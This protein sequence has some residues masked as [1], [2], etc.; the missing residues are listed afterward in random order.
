MKRNFFFVLIAALLLAPWPVVYAYDGVNAD[1]MT[2]AI[3]PAPQEYGPQLQA[4][5]GAVGHVTPGDLFIIDITGYDAD[6]NYELIIANADELALDFRFMNMKVGIF[7]QGADEQHWTRLTAANGDAL[8]EIYI[9]MF[10][11]RVD[12]KL[13]G[14]AKYKIM[15]DTGCFYCYGARG[16]NDITPP[17]FYISAV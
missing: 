14:G 13:P 10:G 2:S 15:I 7:I 12:F 9:T 3:E 11:G 4:Y 5:G 17:T 1:S 6:A 16:G 8:P